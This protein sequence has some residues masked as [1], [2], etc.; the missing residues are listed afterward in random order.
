M[1]LLYGVRLAMIGR[2]ETCPTVLL[3]AVA[4]GDPAFSEVVRRQL[5][6]DFIACQNPNS[7]TA[8]TTSQMGEYN[9]FVLQLDAKQSTGEFLEYRSGYFNTVFFTQLLSLLLYSPIRQPDTQRSRRLAENPATALSRRG[10]IRGLQP[11]GSFRHFELYASAFVERPIAVRLDSAEMDEHVFAALALVEAKSLGCIKPLHCAFFSHAA[12][13]SITA[14]FLLA[15]YHIPQNSGR[16][17]QVEP[18]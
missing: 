18:A 9:T 15:V 14:N 5:H 8:Q 11:F 3:L 6:G 10:H 17:R 13:F 7:V 12:S 4:E 16:L 1:F 2:S